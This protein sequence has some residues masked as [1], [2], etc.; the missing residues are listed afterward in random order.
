M[1]KIQNYRRIA[2]VGHRK[3][4]SRVSGRRDGFTW[5]VVGETLRVRSAEL[6]GLISIRGT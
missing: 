6:E 2:L 5:I 4:G 3:E 1:I